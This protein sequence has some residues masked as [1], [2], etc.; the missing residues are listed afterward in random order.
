MKE[1]ER[2]IIADGF[3]KALDKT[4]ANIGK[5]INSLYLPTIAIFAILALFLY[6]LA[7]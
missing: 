5:G 7:S 6:F 4:E 1:K 2:Q 3:L